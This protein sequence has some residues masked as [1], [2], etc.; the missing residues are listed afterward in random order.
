MYQYKVKIK[1]VT[2]DGDRW[3]S[4]TIYAESI[5]ECFK[6]IERDYRLQDCLDYRVDMKE[7]AIER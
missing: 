5:E 3:N 7:L 2:Y 6:K 4:A 1:R